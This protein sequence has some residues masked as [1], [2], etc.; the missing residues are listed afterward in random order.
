MSQNHPQRGAMHLESPGKLSAKVHSSIGGGGNFV[1]KELAHESHLIQ[2]SEQPMSQFSR[3]DI[4][5]FKAQGQRPRY[6]E[7]VRTGTKSHWQ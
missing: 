5:V 3:Q 4:D 1:E 2:H 7:N 6:N